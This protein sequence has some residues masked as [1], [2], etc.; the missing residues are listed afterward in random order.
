MAWPA[1]SS[2]ASAA[3]APNKPNAMDP[4]LSARSTC[5]SATDVTWK[6]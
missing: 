3:I 1:M 4:G 6:L 5:A 2:V